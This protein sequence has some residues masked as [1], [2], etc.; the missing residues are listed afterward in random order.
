MW[1]KDYWHRIRKRLGY[2]RLVAS[3]SLIG[4]GISLVWAVPGGA[5]LQHR[6]DGSGAI[7]HPEFASS[8]TLLNSPILNS[9]ILS[10]A[11]ERQTFKVADAPADIIDTATA[12]GSFTILLT[13]LKTLGMAEDLRGYGRF[14]VFAP[15]DTAFGAVPQQIQQ[16]LEGNR[17]LVAKVLAYHVVSTGSPFTTDVIKPP[18]S[19]TTLERS[20]VKITR[21]GGSLYVNDAKVIQTDIKAS[22]GVIHAIDKVLI[23]P[24]VMQQLQ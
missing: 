2:R 10:S 7:A 12:A 19:L 4:L 24:D 3:F 23:P 16:A 14:T 21:R 1:A 13:L 9:P 18:M 22:N 20:P 15:T 6:A 11:F 17:D 5:M 8:I